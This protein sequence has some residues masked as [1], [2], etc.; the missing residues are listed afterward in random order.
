MALAS[1]LAEHDVPCPGC[2]YNLRGL[3]SDRCPECHQ[4][5]Q[6]T[7]GLVEPRLGLWIAGLVALACGLG[8]F[9]VFTLFGSLYLAWSPGAFGPS[10]FWFFLVFGGGTS[11]FGVVVLG[12]IR[13]RRRFR[14]RPL[15]VRIGAMIM[16]WLLAATACTLGCYALT[17][18]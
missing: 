10:L 14:M 8:F 16:A 12:W 1:Y 17:V 15:G 18:L 3:T 9:L 4:R 13:A 5:L 7:V 11:L 2:G 6:L